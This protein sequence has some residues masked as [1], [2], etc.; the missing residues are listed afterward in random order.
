MQ[1]IE[2]G[3]WRPWRTPGSSCGLQFLAMRMEQEAGFLS[4][5]QH[6]R[7]LWAQLTLYFL[8][9][10]V[11]MEHKLHLIPHLNL[12]CESWE[13]GGREG[14]QR[15]RILNWLD[16]NPKIPEGGGGGW[17]EGGHQSNWVILHWEDW[18]EMRTQELSSV[19]V[20]SSHIFTY[21]SGRENLTC[22]R[23]KNGTNENV[24]KVPSVSTV[25]SYRDEAQ[26]LKGK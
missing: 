25:C 13:L 1:L 20:S 11:R 4:R 12:D 17:G 9:F 14:E 26:G 5:D 24:S 10:G 18:I 8:I 23:L 16:I 7:G 22:H 3:D 2:F 6:G 19:T 15:E 21:K